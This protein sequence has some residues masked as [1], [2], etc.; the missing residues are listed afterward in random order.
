MLP[1]GKGISRVQRLHTCFL[2]S[3]SISSSWPSPLSTTSS[4]TG[5]PTVPSGANIACSGGSFLP[6][7]SSCYVAVV[8]GCGVLFCWL[9]LCSLAPC[10]AFRFHRF[11]RISLSFLSYRHHL[12][13]QCCRYRITEIASKR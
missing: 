11:Y 1:L 7:C 13:F 9:V 10:R 4:A 2:G 6:T 5:L 12:S 3:S 8:V